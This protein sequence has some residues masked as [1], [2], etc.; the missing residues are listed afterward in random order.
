MYTC[1]CACCLSQVKRP[2]SPYP[3]GSYDYVQIHSPP[4]NAGNAQPIA[5][6]IHTP[7]NVPLPS[8]QGAQ[9]SYTLTCIAT[10]ASGHPPNVSWT[11]HPAGVV[12]KPSTS[13]NYSNTSVFLTL[14]TPVALSHAGLYT[15]D[16]SANGITSSA[17]YAFNVTG[18]GWYIHVQ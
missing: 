14:P 4:F 17:S 9:L 11:S 16:A 18:E 2:Y 7:T 5:V 13:V 3:Q 6:T 10:S 15:C 1:S 8:V 12:G